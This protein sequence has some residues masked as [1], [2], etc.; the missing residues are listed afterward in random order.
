VP[1]FIPGQRWVS[2]TETNLGLGIVVEAND[3]QLVLSFPAAGERRTYAIDNAPVGRVQYSVGDEIVSMDELRIKVDEITTL[4]G[5]LVYRGAD[6]EGKN[7]ELHELELNAFVQISTPKARLFAGQIDHNKRFELRCETIEQIRRHQ[8]SSV[9]GLLGARVQL[10]SHQ[11]YIAHETAKR[12]APR[13]LLADEVGL[14]KTIEAGL[15]THQQLFSGRASRVMILVP[16]NLVHQWLVEML[17]RFNLHFTILDQERFEATA[18]DESN[19]FEAAQ[20]VLCPISFLV[21][22]QSAQQQALACAWDLLLVDE[23]HHLEWSEQQASPA[24]RCVEAL[25]KVAQGLLLLTATPE[26]L[27]LDSHFAR[28]RLLD[29]DRYYDLAKFREEE[30]NYQQINSLVQ[31]LLH[32]VEAQESVNTALSPQPEELEKLLEQLA[33]YLDQTSIEPLSNWLA[34]YPSES[35]LQQIVEPLVGALLDRH[36]TGRVLFR[37]TRDNVKGFPERQLIT[38]PLQAPQALVLAISETDNIERH[39][40]PEL[41]LGANWLAQDPRVQWL[42]QWLRENHQTKALVICA[43]ADTAVALE[44]YLRRK[45]GVQSALFH[46]GL[47]LV[48]RDRAAAYFAD[49]E[50]GAQILI[51]SEIGSEGRNFQ[52][53]HHLVLFDLPLNPDLLEQR[54]GRLDRIGQR[55]TVKIHVPYIELSAQATLLRW[56]H[57]GI[58]GFAQ[59]NAVGQ[60]VFQ[61]FAGQ[62]QQC[63]LTGENID[64]LIIETRAMREQLQQTLQQGR[65]K[66]LELSSCKPQEAQQIVARIE[67]QERGQELFGYMSRVFEQFGVDQ[68][69]HGPNSLVLHPGDHMYSSHFPGLPEGGVMV[70]HSRRLALVREDIQFLTWEHPMVVGAMDMVLNEG[71]GNTSVCTLKLPPLKPGSLLLEAVFVLH[72]PAPAQLQLARYLPLTSVRILLD[73]NHKDFTEVLTHERLNQRVQRVK[74]AV[75]RE[76]VRHAQT[77][78]ADMLEQAE[79]RVR[80]QQETLV[81]QAITGMQQTQAIELQR[82]QALAKVNPNIRLQ[83]IELLKQETD[84]LEYYLRNATLNLDALRVI[85][86]V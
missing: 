63:L 77:Q 34:N 33:R 83:E 31:E 18:L 48:A 24:Y 8:Q 49:T 4:E 84:S 29:P 50:E 36:G 65:D 82:L 37:N 7:Q 12:F 15:I 85:V 9:S 57:E 1:V 64:Q 16:E 14:G 68:D 17:R 35:S 51:C 23:A 76:L 54:I 20:L 13:V 71:F 47:D 26:Q 69:T 55:E 42:S 3:R 72:C 53:A 38:H 21:E 5:C 62:L 41:V 10:L 2:E 78:I 60:A 80:P 79:L 40:Y 86:I 45:S 27:G 81:K 11:L 74:K 70:T 73:I 46:E 32:W 75:A 61:H 28:L 59:T 52:F 39:L 43:R 22:N 56:H 19:P 58:N 6:S 44:E 30:A 67:E 66:L 25:A